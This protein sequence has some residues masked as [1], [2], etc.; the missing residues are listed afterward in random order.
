ML[1]GGSS[2]CWRTALRS[3]GSLVQ[4]PVPQRALLDTHPG[5][6]I[7]FTYVGAPPNTHPVQHTPWNA[8]W[9]VEDILLSYKIGPAALFSTVPFPQK[10]PGTSVK[11]VPDNQKI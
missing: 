3:K 5:L 2:F 1:D 7:A 6:C 11:V 8:V 9:T 10:H 4:I